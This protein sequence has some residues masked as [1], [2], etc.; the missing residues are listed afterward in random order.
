MTHD[1]SG[2]P[3]SQA[4]LPGD[5]PAPLAAPEPQ[6]QPTFQPPSGAGPTPQPGYQPQPPFQPPAFGGPTPQPGQV[7]Y[8][9]APCGQPGYYGPPAPKRTPVLAILSLVFAFLA[10]VVGFVLAIVALLRGK[11]DGNGRGLAIAGLVTSLVMTPLYAAVALPVYLNQRRLAEEAE[12]EQTLDRFM[13]AVADGD[14]DAYLA[15]STFALQQQTHATTCEQFDA[16]FEGAGDAGS[17]PS[18]VQVTDVRVESDDA[19]VTT[20]ERVVWDEETSSNGTFEYW[21]V[22]EDGDWLLNSVSMV[23]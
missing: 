10:P 23:D 22:R 9:Q 18:N 12:V 14:C 3:G 15:G 1:Q 13:T 7:P 17:W 6:P 21:M 20:V 8:G 19:W 16:L 5:L 11:V 2:A 4:W